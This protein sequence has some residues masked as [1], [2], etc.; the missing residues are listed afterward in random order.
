MKLA[1]TINADAPTDMNQKADFA[2]NQ[3]ITFLAQE[4]QTTLAQIVAYAYVLQKNVRL[5][6]GGRFF[7]IFMKTEQQ[8]LQQ[9]TSRIWES[10]SSDWI[11]LY[12]RKEPHKGNAHM[13][14]L[15]NT[16]F[17]QS[18]WTAKM[19]ANYYAWRHT[20]AWQSGTYHGHEWE[21]FEIN[22]CFRYPKSIS[23][24][25]DTLAIKLCSEIWHELAEITIEGIEIDHF[26]GDELVNMTDKRI[27]FTTPVCYSDCIFHAL[28]FATHRTKL[29]MAQLEREKTAVFQALQTLMQHRVLRDSDNWQIIADAH[30]HYVNNLTLETFLMESTAP[31]FALIAYATVLKVNVCVFDDYKF[32]YDIVTVP[33]DDPSCKWVS[34][35]TFGENGVCKHLDF[36]EETRKH[37]TSSS[38]CG[39]PTW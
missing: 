14:W 5:F 11:L 7:D 29:Q 13:Y 23:Q 17:T 2:R 27:W 37:Q 16:P 30:A 33:P 31:A 18:D 36:V 35:F 28:Y 24:S 38:S 15:P 12:V 22:R 34:V 20:H 32:Y 4:T 1:E 21:T 39:T 8:D 25:F 19:L 9:T 10:E 3:R 26:K 6:M